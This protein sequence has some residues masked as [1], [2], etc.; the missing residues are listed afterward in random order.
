[1]S[2]TNEL[3]DPE[4]S[5]VSRERLEFSFCSTTT[6]KNKEEALNK[7]GNHLTSS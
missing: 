2:T 4:S 3:T 5:V 6:K 1:M 7:V